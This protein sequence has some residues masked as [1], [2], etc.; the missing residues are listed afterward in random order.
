MALADYMPHYK[1]HACIGG[2]NTR[3]DMRRL[4]EG[5]QVVVGTPGCV[6]EM[7]HINALS[8]Y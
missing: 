3:K 7:I 5:A 1:C 2:T 4:K 6:F 8:K